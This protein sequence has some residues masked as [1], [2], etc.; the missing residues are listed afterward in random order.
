M[1]KLAGLTISTITILLGAYLYTQPF[2]SSIPGAILL[3]GIGLTLRFERRILKES[4]SLKE[5]AFSTSIPVITEISIITAIILETNYILEASIYLALVMVLT[6]LLNR[7]NSLFD[8]NS[9]RLTGRISRVIILSLGIA[10]AQL[11]SY[12]LFYSIAAASTVTLYDL[13][14]LLDEVRSG[15]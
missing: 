6:D 9:S 11:N 10:G 4:S 1:N 7:F 12:V 3:T 8:I 2:P 13:G 15:I 14:V 5:K